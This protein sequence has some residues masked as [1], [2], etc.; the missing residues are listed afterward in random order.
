M[1]DINYIIH[2]IAGHTP[3]LYLYTP[4]KVSYVT[5]THLL[6]HLKTLTFVLRGKAPHMFM[7]QLL[8]SSNWVQT[9]IMLIIQESPGD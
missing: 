1:I 9:L 8:P 4:L 7:F 3:Y 6:C 2:L 5:D